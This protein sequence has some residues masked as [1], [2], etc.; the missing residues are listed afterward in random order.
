M[1]SMLSQNVLPRHYLAGEGHIFSILSHLKFTTIAKRCKSMN[2]PRLLSMN[3]RARQERPPYASAALCCGPARGLSGMLSKHAYRWT[4]FAS[5]WE[6]AGGDGGISGIGEVAVVGASRGTGLQCVLYLA[7][8][9]MDC[10]AI[11]RDPAV[12]SQK[13]PLQ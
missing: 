6:H 12:H 3:A 7:R 5:R 4:P 10:R 9:K 13:Y 2:Q 8:K 1:K 11:A